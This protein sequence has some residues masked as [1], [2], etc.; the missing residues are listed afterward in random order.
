MNKFRI[1]EASNA[2]IAP[3]AD[4]LLI[5]DS[6]ALS[7][8]LK[9]RIEAETNATVHLC[10]SFAEAERALDNGQFT[11]ALTGHNLPDAAD[12]EI[13]EL[14]TDR[15]VPTILFSGS[16]IND[17]QSNY[18]KYRLVDYIIKDNHATLDAAI[19]AV[20]KVIAN[21]MISVLVVD[22]ANAARTDLV[23][24]LQRQNFRIY[25]AVTGQQALQ[26]L[27]D[28]P[29]IELVITD[30]YMPD[31]DG[32]E[33]TKRIRALHGSDRIRI[34][35]VSASTDR[36]L[37]AQ[38]L[39]AG[40]SDF[41]YRPFVPEELQC[42]VNNNVETLVQLKRLR[43]L[44][45]RDPLTSLYNRRAFFER[46]E[47]HLRIFSVSE[48]AGAIAILD[49]DHFKRINDNFGHETG[50]S[51]LRQVAE[52][53]LRAAQQYK[54]VAAR[55]GGEEFALFLPGMSME[56]AQE[57]CNCLLEDLRGQAFAA[58]GR[59]LQV[60][61]SIGLASLYRNET[62]DNQ[63]NAA[64]QMLYLAKTGGRD[65]VFSEIVLAEL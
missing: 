8:L 40:A 9:R 25:E 35:G 33:L 12:G 30:Y 54:L 6:V 11:L 59:P 29:S 52:M 62:L 48:I 4:V 24:F 50:D 39:K 51:V 34:I 22:D 57:L 27:I 41:L 43:H 18:A 20:A 28:E 19:A 32:Y 60:T 38:F 31:M 36:G 56:D 63:L 53:L 46:A 61:A 2:A 65:R 16:V 13:L 23:G 17:L 7:L 42:R 10:T 3:S 45:E 21:Q 58:N 26:C 55:L 15:D 14:L 5:E 37:S 64:D 1:A 44:A 47:K 49:I